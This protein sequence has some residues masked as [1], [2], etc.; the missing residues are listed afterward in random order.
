M[1]KTNQLMRDSVTIDYTAAVTGALN[2]A[3]D[4]TIPEGYALEIH[5]V[6]F[7]LSAGAIAVDN[8]YK[9]FLLDDPE[10]DADPGHSAEKVIQSTELQTDVSAGEN[11]HHAI[12]DCH[13][14][15]SVKNPNFLTVVDNVPGATITLVCRI[16]FDLIRI[17]KEEI[18]DLLRQQQY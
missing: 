14:T 9:F 4:L 12:M 18:I 17:A 8:R 15:L 2:V 11:W 5:E 16:W 6:E 10:E 13:K 3:F 7:L 1:V